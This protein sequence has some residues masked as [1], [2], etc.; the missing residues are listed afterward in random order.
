MSA[1]EFTGYKPIGEL[2]VDAGVITSAQLSDALREQ[3]KAG[4]ADQPVQDLRAVLAEGG[5]FVEH[6]LAILAPGPP[7]VQRWGAGLPCGYSG[8]RGASGS[9]GSGSVAPP[10]RERAPIPPTTSVCPSRTPK[11]VAIVCRRVTSR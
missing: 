9:V 11:G 5:R 1:A 6:G 8:L 2:L 10:S 4:R 3:R 7:A